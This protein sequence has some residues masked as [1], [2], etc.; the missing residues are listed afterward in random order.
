MTK[1]ELLDKIKEADIAYYNND[2][3]IMSDVE[4]DKLR[5]Q[6]IREY[7]ELDYVPGNVKQGFVSFKHTH[8]I[9]SLD[10]IKYFETDKI[11]RTIAKLMPVV[12][13]PKFD[14]MTVVSYGNKFVTRGRGDVGEILPRFPKKY[15]VNTSEYPIRGEAYITNKDFL[16]I[17]EQ[18]KVNGLETFANARNACAGLLR[19]LEENPYID[20]IKFIVYD[21]VGVDFTEIE[22]IN[23]IIEHTNFDVTPYILHK[24]NIDDVV[25]NI[26]ETYKEIKEQDAFPIDGIV[27]KSNQE[28]SLKKFGSTKHHPLNAFAYKA[29]DEIAE[30]KLKSI[31]WQIGRETLTPVAVFDTVILDGTE[32]SKA[33]LS[34]LSILKSFNFK[35]GDCIS[36]YK[37]NQIIPQ[38]MEKINSNNGESITIPIYCPSCN[39]ELIIR[40][41]KNT[42]ELVCTNEMCKGKLTNRIAYM[43]SKPCLNAKGLSVQTINKLI[44]NG[45]VNAPTDIFNITKENLL[46]I[47]GFKD[48][49]ANNLVT[50][51]TK[52]KDNVTLSTFIA[53]IGFIG[54]GS[55][56]GKLL[57]SKYKTYE[58]VLKVLKTKDKN[59]LI[60]INGIGLTTLNKLLSKEFIHEM[61][62]LYQYVKPIDENFI[63]KENQRIFVI[64]GKLSKPRNF[65]VDLIKSKG[66]KVT[67]TVSNQTT[68]LVLNDKT[69]TSS[70]AKNARKLNIP[71]I[72]EEELIGMLK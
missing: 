60:T 71:I 59:S 21:L 42:E 34:N 4:Y 39:T 46:S 10:K 27:V 57:S 65:Y 23:Y 63:Q 5:S 17:N 41:N 48:K 28:N 38:I 56:V 50:S 19:R 2:S 7:G 68:Y 30:T 25:E 26:V 15:S 72:T 54:I 24:S 70:K 3:P 14:G 31:E 62:M 36:V 55:E 8:N 43:F 40:K 61:E 13:E 49:S 9:N 18:Q 12:I 20:Y 35:I 32:V 22:K 66:D 37:S 51:I 53:S 33:S 1:K 6:Y 47:D 67:D 45:F 58:S 69:S 44:Q 11:R 64:T 29:E 52:S 16:Y